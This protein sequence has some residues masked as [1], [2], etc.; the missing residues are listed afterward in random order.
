MVTSTHAASSAEPTPVDS[1][2]MFDRIAGRYD[3]LNRILSFR[4]DV[5]WR[6]TMGRNL[7]EGDALEVLD[8]ATGTADVLL[9]LYREHARIRRGVGLDMSAGMLAQG[10]G[11][12]RDR[13]MDGDLTLI[14]SD[15]QLIG[16]RSDAFDAA[17]MAFGI[18]NVPNVVQALGDIRRV[19][20]PGGRALILEFSLPGNPLF[21]A[22]YLMYFRHVL[23][24]IGGWVSGDRAA[25]TYLNE[26]V[27]AFPYGD[28]FLGLMGQA[29]FENTRA[30]PL[31]FGIAT[32]YLGDKQA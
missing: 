28:A 21:R 26:S 5:A 8:L 12:I 23:P 32:L 29:G 18:R 31:T 2:R 11:K 22:G 17:T 30:I 7:P 25:Y 9:G 15:A 20:K 24:R 3:V 4:R 13:K 14:R 27:E 10:H 16:L 1:W 6:R 19:L